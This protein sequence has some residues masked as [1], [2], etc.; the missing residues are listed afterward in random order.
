MISYCIGETQ[1]P[2][3]QFCTSTWLGSNSWNTTIM[4]LTTWQFADKSLELILISEKATKVVRNWIGYFEL[5]DQS[6]S[7]QQSL[8][9]SYPHSFKHKKLE[10][11][12][13]LS[14][15]PQTH[16]VLANPHFNSNLLHYPPTRRG[17]MA[18]YCISASSTVAHIHANISANL[19]MLQPA[20]QHA[21]LS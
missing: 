14:H 20:P 17:H 18:L 19:Q 2:T 13:T 15:S 5:K 21:R 1:Q 6:W 7:E 12:H 16:P 3:K 4:Q 8:K 10:K 9:Y 11:C